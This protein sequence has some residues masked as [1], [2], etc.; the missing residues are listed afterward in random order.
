MAEGRY[1]SVV[2]MAGL[3]GA[4][5]GS[6]GGGGIVSAERPGPADDGPA[7][8]GSLPWRQ[9]LTNRCFY[10]LLVA[11]T[12][13]GIGYAVFIAWLPTFY[14][15]AYHVDLKS[16]SWL[17][18]LP[19]AAMAIG[20]NASGW[21]ADWA[22]NARVM[23]PTKTRKTLQ[24]IGNLGP[25]ACLLMLSMMAPRNGAPAAT[26]GGIGGEADGAHASTLVGAVCLLSFGLFT[27]GMQAAGFASTHTDISTRYASAL[28]GITNAGSSIGGMLFVFLVGVI[29]DVYGSW[30]LVFQLVAGCNLFSAI[31][32]IT[33]GTSEPQFE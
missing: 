22:I 14:A 10:A 29:L 31:L 23:T 8:S 12:T 18:I 32:F 5:K 4:P 9:V 6:G 3:S 13:F 20:T 21:A 26:H 28:F 16:S 19:F 11:H 33:C 25:A 27:L 30:S 2:Y 24:S 7:V 17:S 1:G 15:Q